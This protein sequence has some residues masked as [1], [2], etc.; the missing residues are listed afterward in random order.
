MAKIGV[1]GTSWKPYPGAPKRG[2]FAS[3]ERV[4]GQTSL[5]DWEKKQDVKNM[6]GCD[7]MWPQ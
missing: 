4:R 5:S 7:N 1:A 3:G 2:R 6:D